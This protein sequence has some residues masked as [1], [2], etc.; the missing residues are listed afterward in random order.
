[1]KKEYW[2]TMFVFL[3]GIVCANIFGVERLTSYGILNGYFLDK[4]SATTIHYKELMAQ[5][6]LVRFKELLILVVLSFLLKKISV[7][8]G[9]VWFL[10]FSLGFLVTASIFNFGWKGMFVVIAVLVPQ[11]ICYGFLLYLL[12]Q[13]NAKVNGTA[14]SHYHYQD[15]KKKYG[16][17][18]ALYVAAFVLMT[19]G[20]VTESYLNPMILKKIL[21]II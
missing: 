5:I 13:G 1:M 8:K 9:C 3:A 14:G 12:W 11:W 7:W 4:L 16:M 2:I 17:I 10:L 6:F 18:A 20:V 19:L 15:R 21:K